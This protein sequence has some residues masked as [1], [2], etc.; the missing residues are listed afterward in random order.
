M[1]EPQHPLDLNR[2]YDLSPVEVQHQALTFTLPT[3]ARPLEAHSKVVVWTVEGARALQRL[4]QALPERR[5]LPHRALAARLEHRL[6][7]IQRLR[8]EESFRE[9]FK[10]GSGNPPAFLYTWDAEQALATVDRLVGLAVRDWLQDDV[11]RPYKNNAEVLAAVQVLLECRKSRQLYQ[12]RSQQ[13]RL[14]PWKQHGNGTTDPAEP[15]GYT[16]LADF[17]ARRLEGKELLPGLGP[18]HRIVPD[19]WSAKKV[20]LITD[21]VRGSDFSLV[22]TLQVISVPGLRQPLINLDV[23]KRRWVKTLDTAWDSSAVSGYVLPRESGRSVAFQFALEPRRLGDDRGRTYMPGEGFSALQRALQ[24]P[25]GLTGLE[26][27]AGAA[28]TADWQVLVNYRTGTA[29]RHS[30]GGGVPEVDKLA[31]FDAVAAVFA[32]LGLMPGIPMTLLKT[33]NTL[34]SLSGQVTSIHR[35]GEDL[36]QPVRLA[37]TV[38][39]NQDALKRYHADEPELILFHA[40]ELGRE[41]GH[42][43]QVVQEVMGGHLR[44]T[45]IE[46]PKNTHGLRGDLPGVDENDPGKRGLERLTAWRGRTDRLETYRQNHALVGCM[47]LASMFPGGKRED[48]INK[49]AGRRALARIG[50]P[51]QYLLPFNTRK[52]MIE[53]DFRTRAENALR[54]LVWKHHGRIDGL[55]AAAK[56]SF[57]SGT[58]PLTVLGVSVLQTNNRRDRSKGSLIPVAFRHDLRTGQTSLCYIREVGRTLHLEPWRPLS[59]ALTRLAGHTPAPIT[60][61]PRQKQA[62]QELCRTVITQACEAGERPL[63]LLHSNNA[64][65]LWGWLADSR[66]D[67]DHIGF[68]ALGNGQGYEQLW[69]EAR[70]VRVRTGNAPQLVIRKEQQVMEGGAVK[71]HLSLPS[72]PNPGLYRLDLPLHLPTYL[73]VGG[74]LGRKT[75]KGTS[76]YAARLVVRKGPGVTSAKGSGV[77]EM[78]PPDTKNWPTPNPIELV[79]VQLQA[80]DDQDAAAMFV[81]R[82][83]SGYGHHHEWSTL[84][85]PLSFESAARDYI[86]GFEDE[87]IKEN[88]NDD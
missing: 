44:V 45:T 65:T 31:A 77:L 40:P 58:E 25:A 8:T 18:V 59:E 19:T 32:P 53:A 37:T 64:V 76:S 16:L 52:R 75:K 15:L 13:V 69:K 56:R 14:L 39:A 33:R 74:K 83:R 70:I 26:I 17:L 4:G 68:D 11:A 54:D 47:V 7:L 3:D 81:E 23:R 20:E 66:I 42:L 10:G 22:I 55:Q 50:L 24:L 88:T 63:V 27:A 35:I 38:K 60:G 71:A 86:I 87:I 28:S 78:R 67:P 48:I 41:V 36:Q 30:I 12:V 72:S 6:P 82:L 79:L 34:A 5:Q 80:G 61:W 1:T 46:L 85:A 84:P 57:A 73:S 43:E 9:I 21:P 29:S 2:R 51:S 49:V 62:L